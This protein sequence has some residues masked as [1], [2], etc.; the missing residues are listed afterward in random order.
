MNSLETK[1]DAPNPDNALALDREVRFEGNGDEE[2]VEKQASPH[3]KSRLRPY[4]LIAAMGGLERQAGWQIRPKNGSP[5]HQH[6]EFFFL[7][8]QA[9]WCFPRTPPSSWGTPELSFRTL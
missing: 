8:T 2:G 1:A 3:L 5:L 6:V 4:E 9:W 7:I